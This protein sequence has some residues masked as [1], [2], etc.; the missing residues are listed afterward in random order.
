MIAEPLHIYL[1]KNLRGIIYFS[2]EV[3]PEAEL[4]WLKRKFRYR[5]LGISETLKFK[6]K[7][8]KLLILPGMAEDPVLDSLFQ[9]SRYVCPL[10]VL[11]EK[12]LRDFEKAIVASLKTRMKLGD[13]D[14]KFNVRLVNYAIT[15]FYLKSIE[16]A[17][18]SDMAARRRLAEKDLKRFWRIKADAEGKTIVA[19]IDPLLIEGYIQ[20]PALKSLIPS[21]ILDLRSDK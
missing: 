8:K 15:D 4:E 16:F 12:S 13:K 6:A 2:M 17:E 3:S 20:D 14:L 21:I 19:Y 9:A 11:K 7:W 1:V 5:E 18:K 10:I